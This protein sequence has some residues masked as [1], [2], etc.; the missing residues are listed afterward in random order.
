MPDLPDGF[1]EIERTPRK[2]EEN[3]LHTVAGIGVTVYANSYRDFKL[4]ID[5]YDIIV[6]WK[7]ISVGLYSG[8]YETKLNNDFTIMW[9]IS[10]DEVPTAVYWIG[11][12]RL[13]A[14]AMIKVTQHETIKLVKPQCAIIRLYN[15]S[16]VDKPIGFMITGIRYDIK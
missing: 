3:T 9:G 6:L 1:T 15:N 16:N 11:R 14:D 10:P 13:W 12:K 5:S 8:S 7:E 4:Y 2:Y